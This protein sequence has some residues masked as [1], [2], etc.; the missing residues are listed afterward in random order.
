[1]KSYL[2]TNESSEVRRASILV[3]ELLCQS[4]DR[5]TWLTIVGSELPSFYRLILHLYKNDNDE[6][7]RLH[8]QLALDALNNICRDFL[9][10]STVL[11]KEIRILSNH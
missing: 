11:E 3:I 1:M 10:P 2:S 9:Q 8:A 5:S 7:V 4:L 6:I